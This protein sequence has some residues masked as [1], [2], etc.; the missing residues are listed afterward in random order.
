MGAKIRTSGEPIRGC[1]DAFRGTT[2][3]MLSKGIR[4]IHAHNAVAPHGMYYELRN[5][6]KTDVAIRHRRGLLQSNKYETIS[7][8]SRLIIDNHLVNIPNHPHCHSFVICVFDTFNDMTI[9][10]TLNES[11]CN[12]PVPSKAVQHAH[13][14]IK[15]AIKAYITPIVGYM[16]THQD[17]FPQE[18]LERYHDIDKAVDFVCTYFKGLFCGELP[19]TMDS[20][21]FVKVRQTDPRIAHFYVLSE[22]GKKY[23]LVNQGNRSM[24]SS[25]SQECATQI[26]CHQWNG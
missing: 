7:D 16:E 13:M 8:E 15:R 3:E 21:L 18:L 19:Q 23:E 2:I 5:V 1:L 25:V 22:D 12:T 4:S 20:T 6:A 17:V 26:L 14:D 11:R 10:D 24:F 9:P